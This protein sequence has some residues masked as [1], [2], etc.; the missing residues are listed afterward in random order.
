MKLLET[1]AVK[2]DGI[3]E[4]VPLEKLNPEPCVVAGMAGI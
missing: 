1:G 3:D 2:V 4:G